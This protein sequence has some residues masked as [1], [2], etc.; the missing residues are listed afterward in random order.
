MRSGYRR[1]CRYITSFSWSVLIP[2]VP[3]PLRRL[4]EVDR[5]RLAVFDADGVLW[6]GDVSEDFTRWMIDQGH[7]D[8]AL[9]A[10]YAAAEAADP[11]RGCLQMLQFY[12]GMHIESVRGFV[13]V[14]QPRA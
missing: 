7:F 8:A 14:A 13:I 12:K 5:P 2:S 4:A 3:E 9:W 11:A 10:D 6:H 1:P